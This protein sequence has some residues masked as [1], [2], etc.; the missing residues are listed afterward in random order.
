M[1][2][3]IN[4][5]DPLELIKNSIIKFETEKIEGYIKKA[6]KSGAKPV[7]IIEKGI[8]PG[9]ELVGEKF[10]KC[11]FYLPELVM[12]GEVI[13]KGIAVVE[14]LLTKEKNA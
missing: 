1:E 8:R 6:L 3:E 2:T 9:A 5:A 13:K 14:P 11:E 4:M 12:A 7:E 10:N